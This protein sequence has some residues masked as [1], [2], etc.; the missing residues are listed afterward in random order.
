MSWSIIH[1]TSRLF[2]IFFIIVARGYCQENNIPS[3][4]NY[5]GLTELVLKGQAFPHYNFFEISTFKNRLGSVLKE[6]NTFG[7]QY[8]FYDYPREKNLIASACFRFF[9][10]GY[11]FNLSTIL[12]IYLPNGTWLGKIERKWLTLYQR[13][14]YMFYDAHGN[15][16]ATAYMTSN[17]GGFFLLDPS[18]TQLLVEYKPVVIAGAID[19]WFMGILQPNRIPALFLILFAAFSTDQEK[20][21]QPDTLPADQEDSSTDGTENLPFREENIVD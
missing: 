21:F 14:K 17:H 16:L 2:I 1:S 4:P 12:D 18:D 3:P 10:L 5:E 13:G 6:K 15:H 20:N 8:N 19:R 11:I 7:T 9:S